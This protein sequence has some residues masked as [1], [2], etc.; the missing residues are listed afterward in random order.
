MCYKGIPAYRD[1]NTVVPFSIYDR[2]LQS[3]EKHLMSGDKSP[4]LSLLS[5][6][7]QNNEYIY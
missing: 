4:H 7:K 2:K 6:S 5:F 3:I 1:I